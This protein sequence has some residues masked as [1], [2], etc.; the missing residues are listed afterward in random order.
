MACKGCWQRKR[1]DLGERPP[2]RCKCGWY[3]IVENDGTWLCSN[4]KCR[5]KPKADRGPSVP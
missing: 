3:F 5:L 4:P 2:E 1:P